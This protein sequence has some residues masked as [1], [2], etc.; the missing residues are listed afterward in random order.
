M[1]ISAAGIKT[2]AAA[3]AVG[4]SSSGSGCSGSN[5]FVPIFNNKKCSNISL[6]VHGNNNG[7]LIIAAA[8]AAAA[9]AAIFATIT[10]AHYNNLWFVRSINGTK[11]HGNVIF[12]TLLLLLLFLTNIITHVQKSWFKKIQIQCFGG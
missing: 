3:A 5:T 1:F 4:D 7:T 6:F 11:Y 12:S 8:A 2:A 10:I 9:A